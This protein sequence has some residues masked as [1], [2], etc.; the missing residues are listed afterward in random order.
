MLDCFTYLPGKRGG[1]MRICRTFLC[2]FTVS[3]GIIAGQVIQAASAQRGRGPSDIA[4]AP[5]DFL[6]A[7]TKAKPEVSAAMDL[8][9][10]FKIPMR[11]GV[12]LNGT[13]FKPSGQKEGL[14]VIFTLTPY[15][16]DSYQERASYFAKHGYVFV[17]IDARG[18]G[19][20]E[21]EFDP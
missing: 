5:M 17:L 18:R 14:P 4:G 15:I 6:V 7:D 3:M 10:A 21:G 12:R 9:W 2:A 16:S 8:I 11:D 1:P 20:S 19:S 13:V